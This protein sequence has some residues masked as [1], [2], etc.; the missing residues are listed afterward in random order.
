VIYTADADV[1]SFCLLSQCSLFVLTNLRAIVGGRLSDN[2]MKILILCSG[3]SN[4]I[5]QFYDKKLL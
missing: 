4:E 1:H 5:R 2:K 3:E